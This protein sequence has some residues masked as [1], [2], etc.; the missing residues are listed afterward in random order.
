MITVSGVPKGTGT[1][2]TKAA[3]KDES[4]KQALIVSFTLLLYY[5]STKRKWQRLLDNRFE[6]NP[7]SIID[8]CFEF[9]LLYNELLF[10]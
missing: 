4:A 2:P 1:A 9:L 3:A 10:L 6:G 7:L 8:C 5:A